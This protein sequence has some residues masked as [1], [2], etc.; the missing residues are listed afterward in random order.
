[1]A[2]AEVSAFSHGGYVQVC[3]PGHA[4]SGWP[5][6]AVPPLPLTGCFKQRQGDHYF[7][8]ALHATAL[9]VA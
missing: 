4:K 2:D 8:R 9:I 6:Y 1:M 5:A 3:G 7:G